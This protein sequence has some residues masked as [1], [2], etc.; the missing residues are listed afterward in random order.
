[1]PSWPVGKIPAMSVRYRRVDGSEGE[2]SDSQARLLRRA[3]KRGHHGPSLLAQTKS[4]ERLVEMSDVELPWDRL[5]AELEWIA[6]DHLGGFQSG[7]CAA[8]AER[9]LKVIRGEHEEEVDRDGPP[10]PAWQ[11]PALSEQQRLDWLRLMLPM[12]MELSLDWVV[13]QEEARADSSPRL[14]WLRRERERIW[15]AD[16]PLQ[17]AVAWCADPPTPPS[18]TVSRR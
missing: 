5:E 4:I 18:G 14:R 15:E 16:D 13:S 6:E 12:D 3:L 10:A 8:K 9:A 17:A 1:M 11:D 2:W 7:W